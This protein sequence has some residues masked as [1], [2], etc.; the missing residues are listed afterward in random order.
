V[1]VGLPGSTVASQLLLALAVLFGGQVM[2]GAGSDWT[3]TVKLQLP[4]P[5]EEVAVT[6]VVPTGKNEPDAGVEVTVPQLPV[7]EGSA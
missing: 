5:V 3:V 6:T 7:A 1:V 4:S 2:V